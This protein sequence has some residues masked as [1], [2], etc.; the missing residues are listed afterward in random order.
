MTSPQER[1]L[2]EQR[3]EVPQMKFPQERHLREQRQEVKGEQEI[4]FP[5]GEKHLYFNGDVY[6]DQMETIVN[7]Q[8]F[9]HL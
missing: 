9:Q 6:E 7:P 3:Q 5:K 1:Q 2:R 8:H 4:G